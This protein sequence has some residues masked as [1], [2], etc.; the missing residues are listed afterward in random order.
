M[1]VFRQLQQE[2]CHP[3]GNR[4]RAE[5]FDAGLRFSQPLGHF[6]QDFDP[7]GRELHQQ[8]PEI[9]APEMA[10]FGGLQ[11]LGISLQA[12]TAE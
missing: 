4:M 12:L 11:G 9:L 7:D 10:D 3:L 2:A 5:L 8:F 6:F 1:A